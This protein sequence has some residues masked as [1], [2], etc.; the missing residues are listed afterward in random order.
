LCVNREITP[1]RQAFEDFRKQI[2][3]STALQDKV[4]NL[5]F[6]GLIGLAGENGF[7]IDKAELEA[8]F[9]EIAADHTQLSDFE[10]ELVSGGTAS[11]PPSVRTCPDDDGT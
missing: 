5:D 8:Y 11:Q 7:E 1:S 10:L 3:E 6:Q 4:R 2:N 9:S